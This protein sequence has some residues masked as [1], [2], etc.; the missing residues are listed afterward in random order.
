MPIILKLKVVYYLLNIILFKK[1]KDV[2]FFYFTILVVTRKRKKYTLQNSLVKIHTSCNNFIFEHFRI[3]FI[4][5]FFVILQDI[6]PLFWTTFLDAS[7]FS[8]FF[9]LMWL[10]NVTLRIK[11]NLKQ[12]PIFSYIFSFYENEHNFMLPGKKN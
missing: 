10:I 12:F 2:I 9:N 7:S 4:H 11:S 6:K 8:S 1:W 3:I 5:I